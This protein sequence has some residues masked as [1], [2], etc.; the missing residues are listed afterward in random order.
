MAW[1][2]LVGKRAWIRAVGSC[3]RAAGVLAL[4]LLLL[5][6]PAAARASETGAV[7][8]PRRYQWLLDNFDWLPADVGLIVAA[9]GADALIQPPLGALM[10]DILGQGA[11]LAATRAAWQEFARL[12]RL[13]PDEAFK[14]M[15]A[16]RMVFA[17]RYG[18]AAPAVPV[19]RPELS[20]TPAAQGTL[21]PAAKAEWVLITLVDNAM[22]R[23]LTQT[24][25]AAPRSIQGGRP[26]LVLEGGTF[27]LDLTPAAEQ[28]RMWMTIGPSAAAG[29]FDL[30]RQEG[31]GARVGQKEPLPV[32][33][34]RFGS[35]RTMEPIRAM[36]RSFRA[37]MS[38]TADRAQRAVVAEVA[39]ELPSARFFVFAH[40]PPSHWAG[41][42][43][44]QLGGQT[45]GQ[46]GAS[47]DPAEP[48]RDWIAFFGHA[49]GN[50]VQ[51]DTLK[52]SSSL[53][54]RGVAIGGWTAAPFDRLAENALAAGLVAGPALPGLG[55]IL[56][57][58]VKPGLVD[59][60]FALLGGGLIDNGSVGATQVGGVVEQLGLPMSRFAW[61][62]HERSGRL[63]GA[64]AVETTAVEGLVTQGDVFM[65]SVLTPMVGSEPV[66]RRGLAAGPGVM[67]HSMRV[68]ETG[69]SSELAAIGSPF[70]TVAWT[71]RVCPQNARADADRPSAWW[72]V[73]LSPT[74]V[75]AMT[76]GLVADPSGVPQRWLALQVVQPR[77][78]AEA[79]V[80][81]GLQPSLALEGLKR[82]ERIRSR[83]AM[84]PSG[85]IL[86]QAVI[87]AA[88]QEREEVGGGTGSG[89]RVVR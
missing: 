89:L 82:I 21:N 24:M 25:R 38:E 31:P 53:S 79:M 51:L 56:P 37:P 68:V 11:P 28:G 54:E 80:R 60:F 72:T 81:D 70:G 2:S 47:D 49:A 85:L 40:W 30:A 71:Y 43:D 6:G 16:E 22:A 57:E 73:G 35:V 17:V 19:K 46:A 42:V 12:L 61:A 76:D 67:D 3:R 18:E 84:L 55:P 64:I 13:S 41:L 86:G 32:A 20:T 7:E 59:G 9:E 26:E 48:S 27:V 63:D 75:G 83:Q 39:G 74:L 15:L 58:G 69:Q 14:A 65:R 23:K 8:P 87:E 50:M 34:G 62:V 5:L 29:L 77:A 4:A 45:G 66:V 44:G 1:L 10:Q 36:A 88:M 78:L 33:A 52:R